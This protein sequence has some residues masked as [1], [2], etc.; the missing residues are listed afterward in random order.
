MELLSS[1]PFEGITVVSG[2]RSHTAVR[3]TSAVVWTKGDRFSGVCAVH[4]HVA[5]WILIATREKH[6]EHIDQV[7]TPVQ[8]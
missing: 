5:A 3:L 4:K 2:V 6:L 8:G 1:R 7:V